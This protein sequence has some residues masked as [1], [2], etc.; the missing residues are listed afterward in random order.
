MSK[1]SEEARTIYVLRTVGADMRSY[2]GF[3]WP[4]S[5]PVEARDWQPTDRCGHGLHG[6]PWGAGCGGYLDWSGDARW[7]VVE[8]K[9]DDG[10]RTGAG[11][12]MEKCKFRSG[13][14][15][16]CGDRK[17]AT[18]DIIA[19]GA[20]PATVVGAF[21]TGGYESTLT[22]GDA[23][24]LTGGD[25]ST[26]TGGDASTLTGGGGSTLTWRVWDGTYYR[27]HTVYVGEGGIKADVA[28]RWEDGRAVE[29]E[30]A[31]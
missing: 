19:R 1:A 22:G 10:Y 12:L 6:L 4:V 17:S 5:G 30:H 28:Y 20:D 16:H 2:N 7:L 15:V 18:D 21:L 29:V 31:P 27:L 25:E 14:V 24:T 11:E 8:V 13:V 26:L 23:S 9:N 3:Q